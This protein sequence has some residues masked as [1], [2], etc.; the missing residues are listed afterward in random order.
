MP[1]ISQLCLALVYPGDRCQTMWPER[2]TESRLLTFAFISFLLLLL[3]TLAMLSI[4]QG[5]GPKMLS[6]IS[7]SHQIL[8]TSLPCPKRLC[9]T[10]PLRLAHLCSLFQVS[11]Y[12]LFPLA[13]FWGLTSRVLFYM[14][15]KC[16]P[17]GNSH[18]SNHNSQ[19]AEHNG[20]R[21]HQPFHHHCAS[22]CHHSAWHI[23]AEP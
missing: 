23:I 5:L 15:T 3:R 17:S 7:Y 11:V 4:S 10:H 21:G 22:M 6:L 12:M 1:H 2:L 14:L 9:V 20:S 8:K 13:A 16:P 18:P 19:G